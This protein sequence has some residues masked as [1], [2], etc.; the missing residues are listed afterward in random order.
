MRGVM[1]RAPLGGLIGAAMGA[2]IGLV[3]MADLALGP[4]V[5]LWAAVGALFGTASG[6]VFGGG[7][8]PE[9]EGRVRDGSPEITIS[10]H[11]PDITTARAA[12][13][14]LTDGDLEA[15]ARAR[16]RALLHEQHAFDP[17][18]AGGRPSEEELRRGTATRDV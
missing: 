7:R 10:V 2:A 18:T 16:R 15:A 12:D 5:G 4:R 6:F 3:P 8:Q 17:M 14:L 1:A 11:A 13:A 9:L